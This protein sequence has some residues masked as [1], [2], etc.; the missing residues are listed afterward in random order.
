MNILEDLQYAVVGKFSYGWPELE[1]LRTCMPQ[2]CTIKGECRIGLLRNRHVLI[3]L[4]QQEDFINLMSKGIYYILAK[5][6]YSY[7]MRPLIYDAKCKVEEE[8]TQ[9]M[10]WISF[11]DLKPTYFVKEVLFSI[12]T[13]VGK[14]LHLDM[15]TINKT[16]PSCA[17]VKVQVDLLSEFPKHVEM[18]IINEMTKESRMENVKIQ[19]D[20]LPKYCKQC[21]VQGHEDEACRK[22]HPKLRRIEEYTEK[23]TEQGPKGNNNEEQGNEFATRRRRV[24]RRYWKPINIQESKDREVEQE[25]GLTL[26]DRQQL[27]TTMVYAKCSAEERIEL[28]NDLYYINDQYSEPWMV[29]GNFNVILGEDEKIRGLPV[30]IQKYE[31]FAFC[32]NFCALFAINFSGSPFTWWNGRS[33]GECI[34]KRLDRVIGSDQSP[35][36]LKYGGQNQNFIKPFTFLRFWTDKA[37]FKDVVK[38][39]WNE[40][41]SDDAFLQWKLRLKC[42]KMALSKWS[43]EHFGDIFK[44]LHIREEIARMNEDLYEKNP[45]SSNRAILQQAYAEYKVYLHYEEEFWR[46][47]T[48]IQWHLEGDRNTKYFHGLVRGR[49]KRLNIQRILKADGQWAQGE[50]EVVV[51]PISFFQKQFSGTNVQ[52]D[53]SLLQNILPLVTTE[54]NVLL[55]AI[56]KENE[57]KKV[58]QMVLQNTSFRLVER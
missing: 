52:S 18:E 25:A 4:D 31:D 5:D 36:L 34:F 39:S 40:V 13:A 30:Y 51:E 48:S 47:K 32:I 54:E 44:Q 16:S 43:R 1:E 56:P 3:R 38:A 2:Q 11:P 26:E 9:A 50:D 8:T 28:W 33:D 21:K 23:E 45:A 49:R 14:P 17:R 29:G 57:I 7:T 41:H 42:T 27:L 15:T 55:Q 20:M 12:A 10:A 19:Y 53:F 22:L 37:E 24:I 35:L 58:V 6:G 46:Q